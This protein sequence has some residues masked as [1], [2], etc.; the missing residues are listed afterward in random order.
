MAEVGDETRDSEPSIWQFEV[1]IYVSV[2]GLE[3]KFPSR[4]A[5]KISEC[6][7]LDQFNSNRRRHLR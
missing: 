6:P 7:K 1:L 3:K 2:L 4:H 5:T